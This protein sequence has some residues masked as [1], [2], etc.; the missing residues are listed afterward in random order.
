[1]NES[2]RDYL[3]GFTNIDNIP[4]QEKAF[5]RYVERNFRELRAEGAH[6]EKIK[7]A[8]WD[9]VS[10]CDIDLHRT[11]LDDIPTQLW[12]AFEIIR[13][14]GGVKGPSKLWKVHRLDYDTSGVLLFA[15]SSEAARELCRQFREKEVRKLYLAEV[16][17]IPKRQT[18]CINQPLAPHPEPQ[19]PG[20]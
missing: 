1:M 16:M 3:G 17:G 19:T 9:A 20:F 12:S 8:M 10:K 11:S 14:C 6:V 15:K 18:M 5:K 4:R 2:V 13:N 7:D